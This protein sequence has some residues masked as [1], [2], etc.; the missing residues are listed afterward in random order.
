MALISPL[1]VEQKYG[2]S[3]AQLRHWRQHGI[4][5]EYFQFT[6]RSICYSEEYLSD[7]FGYPANARLGAGQWAVQVSV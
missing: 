6:T 1:I 2:I 3:V 5:P 7:W 4:G